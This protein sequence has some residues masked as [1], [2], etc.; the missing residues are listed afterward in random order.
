MV[1]YRL[2]IRQ[3]NEK[4]FTLIETL[5][6]LVITTLLFVITIPLITQSFSEYHKQNFIDI[7]ASDVQ[8]IQ[9]LSMGN[10]EFA[11]IYLQK[12]H[13]VLY[14][15]FTPDQVWMRNYPERLSAH[16]SNLQIRFTS[17][18]QIR[19]PNSIYMKYEDR[20]FQIIFPFGKG[21]FYVRE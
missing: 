9:N 5:L 19:D 15:S 20:D 8:L 16:T 11:R 3:V 17:S 1:Q 13:Y 14:Q 21:R 2:I 4:G 10:N 12:D 6:A 7:L 18:G